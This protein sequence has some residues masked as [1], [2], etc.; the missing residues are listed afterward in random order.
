MTAA[1]I[2]LAIAGIVT[3]LNVNRHYEGTN[4]LLHVGRDAVIVLKVKS[5]RDYKKA[6]VHADYAQDLVLATQIAEVDSVLE[7]IAEIDKFAIDTELR[8]DEREIVASLHPSENQTFSWL[9]SARISN[10]LEGYNLTSE[11]AKA[12]TLRLLGKSL[13]ISIVD[14]CIFLSTNS[15]LLAQALSLAPDDALANDPSF[16]TLE[17]TS[18]RSSVLSAYVHCAALSDVGVD[19]QAITKLAN[20]ADWA[21]VDFEFMKKYVVAN[22]FLTDDGATMAA[23]LSAEQPLL[24]G[25][26]ARIPSSAPVF[27]SF[28]AG[29]RGLQSQNFEQFLQK[30]GK[31]DSYRASLQKY[32]IDVEERLSAVFGNAMALFSLDDD[33]ENSAT[34]CL[35]ISAENGTIAQA[36]LG[37]LIGVMH[38]VETPV[39]QTVLSP[40]PNVNIPVYQAFT[41]DDYLFY[42]DEMMPE[43]PRR[44]F[45]RYE[46][47]LLL[48]GS[49]DVLS[50]TLYEI[51]LGRTLSNDADF[52]NFR[53]AFSADHSFFFFCSSRAAAKFFDINALEP[54]RQLALNNF[55][56]LGLQLSNLG[57]RPYVSVS[58][59][60][61]PSRIQAPPTVWQSR[62][63]TALCGRPFAVSNHNTGETEFLVQDVAGKI[64]L[65]N[66]KGLTLWSRPLGERILG[67]VVQIDYYNNKKLQYLFA[68]ENHIHLID[69]NGN[70]TA[71]FPI[72]LPQKAVSGATYIDYG[73]PAEFRIFVACADRSIRLFDRECKNIQGWEML[74]TE[75]PVRSG[76]SH[77]VSGNK[78]YLIVADD[79]RNYIVN[80]RGNERIA[81][82]P[83]APNAHSG[84]Y[85]VRANAADAAFVTTTADGHFASIDIAS[86]A[87][88]LSSLDVV[89]GQK[90]HFLQVADDRFVVLT[91]KNLTVLDGR[92]KVLSS[93]ALQLS[94]VAWATVTDDG[95]IAVWDKDESLAYLYNTSGKT[96]EGFPLPASSPFAVAGRNG[97]R[98]VVAASADGSLN[99]F[100]K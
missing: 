86:G 9:L 85:L 89:S 61:E 58:A 81:L 43:V 74:P 28:A 71:G 45:L 10:P 20:Y 25:I 46:N 78:D 40:V 76:V 92:G 62:L 83:M 60:H 52:R 97:L 26:D 59:L 95:L 98:N 69:R 50:R 34:N 14:G 54:E 31:L 8:F 79:Y 91:P 39:E 30:N 44:F 11:L 27:M 4:P 88:S 19:N 93:N 67:D 3:V 17:R 16:Y 73:N 64:Y 24:N 35:V 94:S 84:V 72:A 15:E 29:P 1:A 7:A 49:V 12:D 6:V 47:T 36:S 70:N 82:R 32:E 65:I 51:M 21:E 99:N 68:T 90:H 23:V 66:P 87:I 96:L 33:F 37:A 55:Y 42:V 80:R 53:M 77:Y 100:L 22:G 48:S 63:D 13:K 41:N 18:A 5:L 57:D 2:I 56:A 75:G 38:N